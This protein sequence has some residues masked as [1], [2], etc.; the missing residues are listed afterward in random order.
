MHRDNDGGAQNDPACV[1]RTPFAT[2]ANTTYGPGMGFLDK[3][4]GRAKE[5]A[6]DV[7]DK[8]APMVDKAQNAADNAWDSAKDMA[9]DVAD[10]AKDK[11]S[12]LTDR[13]DD[14]ETGAAPPGSPAA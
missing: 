3:L 10:E 6:G 4:L 5:T 12:E 1:Q 9:D 13:G 7:A 14:A 8:A 11:V 2:R